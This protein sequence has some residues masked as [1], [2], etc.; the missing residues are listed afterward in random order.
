LVWQSAA[1]SYNAGL[2]GHVL[3][4]ADLEPIRSAGIRLEPGG[5]LVPSDSLGQFQ[6]TD[7]PNGRYLLRVMAIGYPAVADSITLGADGLVVAAILARP[8]GDIGIS[9]PDR[10]QR[11]STT[12]QRTLKYGV[13][14]GVLGA[15]IGA[16]VGNQY[17]QAHKPPC[18]NVPAGPPCRYLD[19]DNS[20]S[21]RGLG[22]GL[23]AGLGAVIGILLARRE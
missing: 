15:V 9:C 4:V 8:P 16:V 7:V 14:G 18:V 12:G 17:A 23:G 11:T 13:I 1:G 21:D 6:F 19:P 22:I 2:S 5:H 3:R 10:S 20:S